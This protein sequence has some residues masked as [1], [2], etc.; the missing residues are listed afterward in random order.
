MVRRLAGC[1]ALQPKEPSAHG[2][3]S[4]FFSAVLRPCGFAVRESKRHQKR[5]LPTIA[6]ARA[7]ALP[8]L[9]RGF[10]FIRGHVE[11]NHVQKPPRREGTRGDF[12]FCAGTCGCLFCTG[13]RSSCLPCAGR[14]F[15]VCPGSTRLGPA[16][17]KIDRRYFG[18]ADRLGKI[19]ALRDIV[20]YT[21]AGSSGLMYEVERSVL[22]NGGKCVG[23]IPQFMIDKKWLHEGLSEVIA[24][25]TM[26]ERKDILTRSEERRVGKECRSR[27]S[28]YH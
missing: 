22:D 20:C 8:R 2:R 11:D 7:P 16:R 25:N 19:L 17:N 3:W 12:P 15:P 23:V 1:G 13:E 18:E 26:A 6:A 9:A 10:H 24:V 28:P 5:R 4:A 14:C 27:W 21:G